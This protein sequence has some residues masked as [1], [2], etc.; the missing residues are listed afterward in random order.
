MIHFLVTNK[1]AC[2]VQLEFP[3][4]SLDNMVKYYSGKLYKNILAYNK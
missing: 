4:N 3:N 2:G 1:T